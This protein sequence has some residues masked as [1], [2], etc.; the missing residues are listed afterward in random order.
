MHATIASIQVGLPRSLGS[1][2]AVDPAERRWTTAFFKEPVE[3]PV[4]VRRLNIAGDGQADRTVHGGLDKAVLAY[5]ADHYRWWREELNLPEMSG[6]GFGENLTMAG[7]TEEEV[8]VGDTWEVSD[9]R[10]QVSQ[11]RQPCWKLARR[12][13]L[14]KLP[15]LVIQTGRSGWYLRV[16]Q[17]GTIEP[18]MPCTLVDRP[19]PTWTIAR[20]NRVF[21]ARP[22]DVAAVREL[23]NLPEL[24]QA[25]REDLRS[26]VALRGEAP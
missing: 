1:V 8:C 25:W 13:R 4:R 12:W 14:A 6:G 2:E 22:R 20:V 9:V 11:P 23:A 16:L 18:G 17:E 19:Q 26:Q 7:V 15:K 5:A 24:S 3:G 10:F 21:Y